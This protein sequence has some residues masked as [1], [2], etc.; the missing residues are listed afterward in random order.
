[1]DQTLMRLC[2]GWEASLTASLRLQLHVRMWV[3][4]PVRGFHD[5]IMHEVVSTGR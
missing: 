3:V 5:R 4:E 1:M 2:G